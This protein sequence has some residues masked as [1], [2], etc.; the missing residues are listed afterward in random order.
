MVSPPLAVLPAEF[1]QHCI[2]HAI[3]PRML[4]H[5]VRLL[6]LEPPPQTVTGANIDQS[7]RYSL[8]KS[9]VQ[10]FLLR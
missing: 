6:Y 5:A 10:E 9:S 1:A 4:T 2:A 3:L 7:V 8:I